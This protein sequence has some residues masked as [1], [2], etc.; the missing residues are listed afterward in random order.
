[1]S[2]NE[3]QTQN[4]ET[5]DTTTKTTKKGKW[6]ERQSWSVPNIPPVARPLPKTPK[7]QDKPKPESSK[8]EYQPQTPK[9]QPDKPKK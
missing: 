6:Y 1:M 3:R 5:Q 2:E 4:V 9:P 8:P 7:P